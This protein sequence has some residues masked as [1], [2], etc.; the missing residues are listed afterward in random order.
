[1]A[2]RYLIK[3]DKIAEG[4]T[5]P[6]GIKAKIERDGKLAEQKTTALKEKK[7]TERRTEIGFEKTNHQV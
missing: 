7:K 2:E 4:V 1:M 6:E 5:V 3:E